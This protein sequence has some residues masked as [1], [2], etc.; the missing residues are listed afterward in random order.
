MEPEGSLPWSQE[1]LT[2]SYSEPDQFSPYHH[3]LSKIRFD[4]I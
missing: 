4:I 2:G 1:P 3:I